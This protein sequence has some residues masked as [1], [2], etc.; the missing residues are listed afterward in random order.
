MP[1]IELTTLEE[2]IY[3]FKQ[4]ILNWIVVKN[5]NSKKKMLEFGE[6]LLSANLELGKECITNILTSII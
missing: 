3:N 6:L 1:R 2:S 5:I 4:E